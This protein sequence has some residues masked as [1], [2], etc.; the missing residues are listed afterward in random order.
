MADSDVVESKSGVTAVTFVN[1]SAPSATIKKSLLATEAESSQVESNE[2]DEVEERETWTRGIDFFLACVGFSV[3]LGNVWRFPYL[4]YKHGGGAFLIPYFISVFLGG[5]PMF[6]IEVCLGQFMSTGG[7]SA[8]AICP[9][10]KGIGIAAA[11]VVFNLN[12]YYNV[13]LAW[14]IRYLFASIAAVFTMVLPW[15]TCHNYWNT[16]NCTTFEGTNA[17]SNK[18][19]L[20]DSATEY[21]ENHILGI[22]KGLEHPGMIKWDLAL[23]LLLAWVIVYLCI[24]KGIKT[25]GKVSRGENAY[26][27]DK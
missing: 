12:V 10:F 2:E 17:S 14:A 1:D 21:W 3:G 18:E 8:W 20:I 25:S 5:I 7:I 9:L 4:C 15:D 26:L 22:S 13:V 23:T 19:G 24:C 16:P 27:N 6:F 11:V